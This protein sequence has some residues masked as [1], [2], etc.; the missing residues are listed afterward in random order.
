[1][2]RIRGT[3][4]P[5]MERM[6]LVFDS[7]SFAL[8]SKKVRIQIIIVWFPVLLKVTTTVFLLPIIRLIRWTLARLDGSW[9][10]RRTSAGF[11][12]IL[13]KHVEASCGACFAAGNH[14]FTDSFSFLNIPTCCNSNGLN[15]WHCSHLSWHW[16][17]Q[18]ESQIVV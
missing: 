16:T 3:R 8:S 9:K 15:V 10:R 1:M 7:H 13:H 6:L 5:F 18:S 11:K 12:E 2:Q 17:R 4:S 14:W